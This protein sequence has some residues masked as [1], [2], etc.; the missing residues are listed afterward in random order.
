MEQE[1]VYSNT[2]SEKPDEESEEN[3]ERVELIIGTQI[4]NLLMLN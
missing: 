2:A 3:V 4:K 1:F